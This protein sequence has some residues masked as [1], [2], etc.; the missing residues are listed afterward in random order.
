MIYLFPIDAVPELV[1]GLNDEVH[2]R[3][4]MAERFLVIRIGNQESITP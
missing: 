4:R 1:E 2:E 3:S